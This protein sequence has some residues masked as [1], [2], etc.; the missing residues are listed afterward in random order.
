M[1]TYSN[2][3]TEQHRDER[4]KRALNNIREQ[5]SYYTSPILPKQYRKV[6]EDFTAQSKPMQILKSNFSIDH[7]REN[8]PCQSGFLTIQMSEDMQ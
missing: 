7:M 6:E 5:F 3:T 8:L 2:A 1:N 4:R